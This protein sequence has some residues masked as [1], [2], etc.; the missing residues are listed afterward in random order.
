MTDT[1]HI[2]DCNTETFWKAFSNEV[3][4]K[5]PYAYQG[6]AMASPLE[7]DE[8]FQAVVRCSQRR[9]IYGLRKYMSVMMAKMTASGIVYL[10]HKL[11]GKK[12]TFQI[13]KV[14]DAVMFRFYIG[15][16]PFPKKLTSMMGVAVKKRYL[17]KESDVNFEGYHR[18]IKQLLNPGWRKWLGLKERN[19]GFA[20][21]SMEHSDHEL[22]SWERG[23]LKPLIKEIGINNAG[24]YNA[25]FVGDYQRTPFGVHFD[26]EGVFHIPIVG[27]KSMR[28]WPPEYVEKNP[29]LKGARDYDKHLSGSTLIQADPGQF[30]YWPSCDWHVG[31][32]STQGLSVSIALSLQ[33]APT[34]AEGVPLCSIEELSHSHKELKDV[35]VRSRKTIPFDPD[36][37]QGTVDRLPRE[38][39]VS[40][41]GEEETLLAW[42]RY[43][44]ALG[45][46]T[47]P[48]GRKM[49]AL[50][51]DSLI[52]GNSDWPIVFV[53][54][55]QRLLVGANGHAFA[56]DNRAEFKQVISTLNRDTTVKV[57]S[58][59]ESYGANTAQEELMRFAERLTPFREV[60]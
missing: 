26:P 48:V 10:W 30:V 46:E 40:T 5:K 43:A 16:Y 19:Y 38:F 25:L 58:L 2:D 4:E 33:V 39:K 1:S 42:L 37:L 35:D 55:D 13:P 9:S 41:Q 50:N 8:F 34:D 28:T 29:D 22:W 7:A 18:R 23:F 59:V 3:W 44:T 56:C 57:G 24:T 31:E 11:L 6:R 54:S 51:S 60:I 21:N 53:E 27:Q 32:S 52:I 15:P 20:I 45:F 49:K 12:P 17:P 47:P 14:D 36:N